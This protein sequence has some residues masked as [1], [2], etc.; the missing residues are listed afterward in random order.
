MK[1]IHCVYDDKFIDGAISLFESDKRVQNDYVIFCSTSELERPFRYIKSDKVKRVCKNSFVDTVNKYDILYLHS[2]FSV[3]AP[4]LL[5][6]K[7]S[8]KIVWFSWGWDY[9]NRNVVPLNLYGPETKEIIDNQFGFNRLKDCLINIRRSRRFASF[10]KVIR[11]IDYFSGV[12]PYEYDLLK[13]YWPQM[14]A[15]PV[16]FYYGSTNFF[17]PEDINHEVKNTFENVL[18]GNSNTPGNNHLDAFNYLKK[19]G[20]SFSG[21]LILPL[22]YGTNKGYR[23]AVV[24]KA[25]SIWGD[26]VLVLDHYLPLDEYTK[27]VSNCKIAVFFHE[28]QQASDNVFMQLQYGAKVYMSESSLMFKYLKSKGYHIY[29]LQ[30]DSDIINENLTNSQIIDNRRLLSNNY[31]SSKLISRVNDIVSILIS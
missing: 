21:K 25:H 19:S 27:I 20:L 14:K 11:R 1:A 12:F 16:D 18:V 23:D 6:L 10:D 4:S 3:N 5:K 15:R 7:D 9:Y 13:E 26:R 31:S 24:S 17:I 30:K 8:V 2:W 22:S 29:S 28:R